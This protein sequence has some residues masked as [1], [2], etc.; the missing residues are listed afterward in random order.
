MDAH[1]VTAGVLG[2]VHGHVRLDQQLLGR[3]LGTVQ[4]READARRNSQSL[5]AHDGCVAANE[6]KQVRRHRARL[7]AIH[8]AE[9]D[10]ELVPTQAG[11]RVRGPQPPVQKPRD[12]PDQLVPG[13]MSEGI[14]D[15]FE[16]V[17]V[18]NQQRAPAPVVSRLGELPGQLLL[19]AMTVEQAGQCIVISEVLELG[20]KALALR[21]VV[22]G[23]DGTQQ[24]AA[25]DDRRAGALDWER[26]AVASAEDVLV[27]R[28]DLALP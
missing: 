8:S 19:E 12:A 10:A 6:V 4:G 5:V 21:D 15:V 1:P 16:V 27:Y 26:R 14:V 20:L 11:D 22:E 18:E 13:V 9:Q 3:Q 23:H 28:P 2:F 17:E 7:G 25:F 24:L